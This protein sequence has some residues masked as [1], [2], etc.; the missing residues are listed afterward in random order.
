[1][2][3]VQ[4]E[5]VHASFLFVGD[6]NGHHQDWLGSTTTNRHCFAAFDFATGGPVIALGLIGKSLFAVKS[7]LMK[8]TW[9]LSISLVSET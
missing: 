6:L 2:T 9:R 5:D 7:E 8:H 3:A 1:M 4:A